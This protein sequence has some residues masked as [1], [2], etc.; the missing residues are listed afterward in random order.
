MIAIA[1]C[2]TI[3]L[4]L[5]FDAAEIWL[6]EST[7][8]NMFNIGSSFFFIT[9]MVISA[10][11]TIINEAGEEIS[12]QT[13]IL[14]N[15]LKTNFFIDLMSS[16]P[17]ELIAPGSNLRLLNILKLLRI[18]RLTSLINNARIDDDAKVT[19]R[20]FQLIFWL[21]TFMHL[22]ACG[23]HAMVHSFDPITWIPPRDAV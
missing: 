1:N 7:I 22:C 16:V 15:Y 6:G 13:K 2:V 11:T 19:A 20:I 18:T 21:I 4:T 10:K 12:D 9:D 23:F 14:K 17:I 3:P 5:S 8:Y